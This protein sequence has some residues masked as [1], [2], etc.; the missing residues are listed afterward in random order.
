MLRLH[1]IGRGAAMHSGRSLHAMK[2]RFNTRRFGLGISAIQ[3]GSLG[4]VEAGA[5]EAAPPPAE[6]PAP[7]PAAEAAPAEVPPAA[8]PAPEA[9]VPEATDAAQP[10]VSAEAPE[11]GPMQAEPQMTAEEDAQAEAL[12]EAE[13][14]ALAQELAQGSQNQAAVDEYD[15]E[16]YGFTDFTYT[17]GFDND[18]VGWDRFAVG[19]MNVYL[20]SELGDGWRTLSE[21]R[22][23]Y[24]PH[25]T[26]TFGPEGPRPR[27]DTSVPDYTNVNRPVRWGGI[28]LERAWLEY[29]A[30]P[31]LNV[32]MGHF[33]T[34]YGI[35][36][37]DH[38]T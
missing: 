22:Y 3:T 31:L 25:G 13:A 29:T 11:A 27:T 7:P 33:L 4:A 23:S 9:A 2:S 28:I 17:Q 38:G 34:P 37:V 20:S 19:N 35:W 6:A 1:F 14:D 32:R 10:P 36:N 15:V 21:V 12:A 16:L 26:T 30:D 18:F 24:L 5:Q 8:E